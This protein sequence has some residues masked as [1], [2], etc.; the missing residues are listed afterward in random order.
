ML[1]RKHLE[2]GS[3][4]LINETEH[5]RSLFSNVLENLGTY[6]QFSIS[7]KPRANGANGGHFEINEEY[8]YN[9]FNMLKE[10]IGQI[11]S[12]LIEKLSG[13]EKDSEKQLLKLLLDKHGIPSEYLNQ[14]FPPVERG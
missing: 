3:V 10:V 2:V 4:K 11:A 14:K 7:C 9:E 6:S 13:E 5:L 1:G 12:N 8:C